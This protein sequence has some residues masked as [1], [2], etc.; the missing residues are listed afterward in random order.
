MSFDI[1]CIDPIDKCWDPQPVTNLKAQ[2]YSLKSNL[3]EHFIDAR[4]QH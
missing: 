2:N 4:F 1:I 3:V